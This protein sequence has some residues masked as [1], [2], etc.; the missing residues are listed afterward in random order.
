MRDLH[1]LSCCVSSQGVESDSAS[2]A[3]DAHGPEGC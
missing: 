1:V 2:Q 3:L